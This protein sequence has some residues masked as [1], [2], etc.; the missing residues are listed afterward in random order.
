METRTI[1]QFLLEL[2]ENNNRDWFHANKGRYQKVKDEFHVFL[3]SLLAEIAKF[4]PSVGDLSP[5]D[6]TFRINRDIRFSPDKSPYKTNYGA[7]IAEGGKKSPKAGY[8]LHLEPGGSFLAGGV[9]M[10]SS[11]MLQAIRQEIDY[12]QEEFKSLLAQKA[13][14]KYFTKLKGDM[15]I[16]TPKGYSKDHPLIDSLRHKSFIMEYPMELSKDSNLDPKMI[17]EVFHAMKPLNDF[18]N[19]AI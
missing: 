12:N 14:K 8:Y 10:P 7:Y 18:F 3:E 13:F 15:L 1:F 16:T 17:A 11:E 2:K 4:D 6:C 5:K 19:H 9:W